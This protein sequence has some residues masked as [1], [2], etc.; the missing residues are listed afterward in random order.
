MQLHKLLS[1]TSFACGLIGIAGLA[2][3]IETGEGTFASVVLL[4]ICAL[5]GLWSAYESGSLKKSKKIGSAT[6]Q[7]NRTYK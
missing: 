1:G 7:A 6:Y 2:G 4:I 3:A 5:F